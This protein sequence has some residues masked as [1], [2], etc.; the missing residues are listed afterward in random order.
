MRMKRKLKAIERGEMMWNID[1]YE[2]NR[3]FAA[4]W[5]IRKLHRVM[6]MEKYNYYLKNVLADVFQGEVGLKRNS[7][8]EIG[9]GIK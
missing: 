1:V 8:I 3:Q 6:K 4:K 5:N 7:F 9:N 2:L